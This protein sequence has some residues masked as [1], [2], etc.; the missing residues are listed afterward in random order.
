MT[1]TSASTRTYSNTDSAV[2]F[3]NNELITGFVTIANR[4]GAD[5]S[6]I[7]DRR[8]KLTRSL[9]TWLEEESL[10]KVRLELRS[11]GDRVVDAF[12]FD[13][14]Y[15]ADHGYIRFP[16]ERVSDAVRKYQHR[17]LELRI[18]PVTYMWS[19][20]FDGWSSGDTPSVRTQDIDNFGAGHI[21]V[22]I[23]HVTDTTGL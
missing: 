1:R 18:V 21:D 12:V 2:T 17:N 16:A 13:V 14:S 6:W 5:P 4:A 20:D 9:S 22:G 23:G 7:V 19:T 15:D 8:D 10:S 11:A 3:V